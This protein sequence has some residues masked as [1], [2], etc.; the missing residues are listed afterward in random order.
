MVALLRV[1]VEKGE[2]HMTDI[3]LVFLK[4]RHRS[5][6]LLCAA[7]DGRGGIPD[8]HGVVCRYPNAC[9]IRALSAL[10]SFLH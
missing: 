4:R 9:H 5:T 1:N 2:T 7:V 10:Q 8:L 3:A 6:K